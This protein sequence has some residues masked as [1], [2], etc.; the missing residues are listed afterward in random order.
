MSLPEHC[1]LYLASRGAPVQNSAKRLN[2]FLRVKL[3]C[4]SDGTYYIMREKASPMMQFQLQTPAGMP[5][6]GTDG[7]LTM[8]AGSPVIQ[9]SQMFQ[10]NTG[11]T[12]LRVQDI[13]HIF[14]MKVTEFNTELPV[15]YL[16]GWETLL[17]KSVQTNMHVQ[18]G[19]PTSAASSTTAT[20]TNT[21]SSKQVQTLSPFVARQLRDLAILRKEQCPITVEDYIVGETAVMPC[22]H[23]FMKSAI[24]E[25]FKKEPN[26]CP[27]CR[28]KGVPTCV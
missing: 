14:R 25:S 17:G 21:Q 7:L 6:L 13:S 16:A 10:H 24:E 20:T 11:R 2:Q 8:P 18:Y 3:T 26:R 4:F 28:E 19:I 9:S 5:T 12:K 23:L 22:G 15:L 1:V 27:Q